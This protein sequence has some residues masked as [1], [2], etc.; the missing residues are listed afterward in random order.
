MSIRFNPRLLLISALLFSLQFCRAQIVVPGT[1][2]FDLGTSNA[3]ETQLWDLTGLYNLSLTVVEHNGIEV[4]MTFSF[5]LTHD[6]KGHLSG[7]T[8]DLE[9][10]DLGDNS[11]FVCTYRISGSVSGSSGVARARF[12]IRINGNGTL[13]GK[14]VENFSAVITVDADTDPSGQLIGNKAAKFDASF[15][16]FGGLHGKIIDFS[17]PLPGGADGTWNLSM[18]LAPLSKVTGT[19]VITTPA[20]ML[21]LDLSGAFKNDVFKINAKGGTDVP[22][23]VSGAGSSAS[24]QLTSSFDTIQLKGKLMGQKLF[25]IFP[26]GD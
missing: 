21:G 20:Q 8:N 19:A 10:L 24:I 26:S 16:G 12:T 15:G 23:T 11:S 6:G 5:N 9:E 1:V 18:Q 25:F 13:A 4:P 3:P 2:S 14:D 7:P 17:T 22:S